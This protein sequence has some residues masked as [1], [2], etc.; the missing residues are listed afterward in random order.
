MNV[1]NDKV[2]FSSPTCTDSD[3]LILLQLTSLL[4]NNGAD[5]IAID[6]CLDTPLHKAAAFGYLPVVQVLL[7]K[8]APVNAR[9]YNLCTPLH[10]AAKEGAPAAVKLLLESGA[11]PLLKDNADRTAADLAVTEEIRSWLFGR[12]N[13]KT[14]PPVTSVF[15]DGEVDEL[16]PP[17]VGDKD[18][19]QMFRKPQTFSKHA[20]EGLMG[21]WKSVQNIANWSDDEDALHTN[22]RHRRGRSLHQPKKK[23]HT[24]INSHPIVHWHSLNLIWRCAKSLHVFFQ[25]AVRWIKKH[26]T[27]FWTFKGSVTSTIHLTLYLQMKKLQQAAVKR[28]H[29]SWSVTGRCYKCK[30]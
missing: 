9:N 14:Q 12:S 6:R 4:L 24:S 29:L 17:V 30:Q 23:R 10:Y 8:G 16:A 15:V 21:K 2:I 26:H 11:D 18:A 13:K 1:C 5:I 22:C 19:M 25:K 3:W 28:D 27:H 20:N 7:K